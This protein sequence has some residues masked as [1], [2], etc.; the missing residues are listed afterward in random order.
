[1]GGRVLHMSHKRDVM[2]IWVRPLMSKPVFGVS[3]Q[4]RHKPD[5]TATEDGH[6]LEIP[7]LRSRG[8]VSYV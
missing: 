5:C 2:L 6:G 4:V 7:D 8:R 1:M 3:D